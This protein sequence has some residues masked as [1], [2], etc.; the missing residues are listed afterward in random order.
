MI[1]VASD[2]YNGTHDLEGLDFELVTMSNC[3]LDMWICMDHHNLQGHQ[4]FS[5]HL[6]MKETKRPIKNNFDKTGQPHKQESISLWLKTY[7]MT[8]KTVP[9]PQ[10]HHC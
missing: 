7:N 9:H 3:K 2:I 1:L 10:E 8:K 4:H 6:K 5:L